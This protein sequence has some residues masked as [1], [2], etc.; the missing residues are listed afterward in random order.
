MVDSPFGFLLTPFFCFLS[1]FLFFSFPGTVQSQYTRGP[2]AIATWAHITNA[3][4]LPGPAIIS[5]LRSAATTT[6]TSLNQSVFTEISAGTPRVSLDGSSESEEEEE[7]AEVV[8]GVGKDGGDYYPYME[9]G[10]NQQDRGVDY[11]RKNS[12]VNTTT[13]ISQTFEPS[14]TAPW[15]RSLSASESSPTEMEEALRRLGPPPHAR[16]LLLIAEMSSE[17]N[18]ITPEY[19]SACLSAARE[20]SDF[21]MGFISQHSLNSAATDVFVNFTPGI[22]LPKEPKGPEGPEERKGGGGGGGR[23]GGAGEGEDK[24]RGDGMGQTWRSPREVVV[25]NGA[26]VIIVGRGVLGAKD[27]KAEADRYRKMAWEAYEQRVGRREG[28]NGDD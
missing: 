11:P 17:G 25:K 20:N 18:L 23:G 5:A 4:L 3:H 9:G 13:T 27:R 6:L 7:E 8:K 19:T 26:D 28:E 1:F 21:V 14:P 10:A 12:V 15:A 2:L 22:N 24:S 16:A